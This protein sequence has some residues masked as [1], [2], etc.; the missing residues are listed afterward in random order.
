MTAL[1]RAWQEGG[2]RWRTVA[3]IVFRDGS[4]AVVRTR[5]ARS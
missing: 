3:G 2:S 4:G 1:V 5:S